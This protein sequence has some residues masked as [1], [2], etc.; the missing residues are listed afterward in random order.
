MAKI[1]GLT[2]IIVILDRSGSM[3]SL[4]K[5]VVDGY[6]GYI[7]EQKAVPGEARVSL[8]QFDTESVD[9]IYDKLPVGAVPPLVLEPRGGTPL[10]DA[11]GRTLSE[12]KSNAEKVIFMIITDGA[13]NSS[14][15]YTLESVKALI[16][17][18]RTKGRQVAF[19]AANIDAFSTGLSYGIS[20]GSTS[21]WTPT[22]AGTQ[23]MFNTVAA[24]AADY[25][26]GVTDELKIDNTTAADATLTIDQKINLRGTGKV[27]TP[28]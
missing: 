19:L 21:Q 7:K 1:K 8:I 28:A 25:R 4:H 13:E 12:F 18:H 9:T 26:T 5:A 16:Q 2:D 15:E 17:K 20:R 14:Q 22:Y 6:N 24:A 3:S 11:V 23:T 10:F 27:T